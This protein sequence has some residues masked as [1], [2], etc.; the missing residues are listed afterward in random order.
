ME[1]GINFIQDFAVVLLVA[2]AVGWFCQRVGLSVVVGYLVAGVLVGPFTPPFSLVK[3]GG[4]IETLAQ[5]GLVFLMFSIGLKLSVRRLRR[6]GFLLLAGVFA[7]AA[8]VYCLT[9]AGGLMLGW[10]GTESLFL[11]AML[12]VSSS[13]IIGKI[14]HD[15][16][17]THEKAGQLAMGVS[18]LEDVVAVVMLTLLNSLVQFGGVGQGVDLGQTLGMFGAFV[19]L[20]GIGGLLIVPWLLKKLSISAGEELQTVTLAGLLFGLALIAQKA[21]YSLALGAFLLGTIVAET[22]HRTQVERT[23]EGMR[24]VFTAVFFVAIGMQ[25]DVRL[26]GEWWWLIVGVA[27]FTV[28]VR[29]LATTIGLSLIGTSVKDSMQVGLMATPIGE[30]SFIIAQLGVAAKVVPERFY[31][32][33]VGVSLLTTL[34]APSLTKHSEKI[35]VWALSRRPGWLRAW[36]GYYYTWIERLRARQKR[37]MLWQLSKK[38]LIQISVEVLLVTGLLVFSEPLFAM[39]ESWLGHNWLFPHGPTVLF[40]AGMTLVVLAPLVAIWRNIS[41]LCLLYAQVSV[42]GHPQARKMAPV[43]EWAFRAVAG[44]ALALWIFSL[45]PAGVGMK[46]LLLASVLLAGVGILILRRRLVYWHSELEVELQGALA[47]AGSAAME[48]NAPWLNPHREWKLSVSDCVLPDLADC[49]GKRISELALRPQFGA[50]IVGID[51]QG[52]LIPLPGPETVLYPRDKVLLIGT[53]EQMAAGKAFLQ[54][55]TGNPS[56]SE[57]EDVRMETILVPTGSPGAGKDLRTLIPSQGNHVQIAGIRRGET[58]VLN[59]A[60][61]EVVGA[62]DELLVLGTPDQIHGFREWLE[63]V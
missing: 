32:M 16:G 17:C 25:I 62:G 13:S 52:C 10:S 27:A 41:A 57:F 7:S 45:L 38:R 46:W 49:T 61:D 58:R 12:M 26:V 4:S 40:V 30:F 33:A 51:R 54:R 31:P 39:V 18:V 37:N 23:F 47:G 6:L 1:H 44:A 19:V 29:A 59:P 15:T 20:A 43:V 50:T 34:G 11:A 36:H 56:G 3:E 8:V 35:S 21:G 24:E 48:T 5:V 2:G 55:V 60:G 53:A 42:S 28:V 9:R 63:A 14:L 22:P